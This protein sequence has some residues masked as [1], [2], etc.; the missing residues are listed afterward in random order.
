MIEISCY[1]CGFE[2][3]N[4]R[5]KVRRVSTSNYLKFEL[6]GMTGV[7]KKYANG[8]YG[9]LLDCIKNPA[10]CE[11]LFWMR[12]GELMLEKEIVREENKMAKLE[13]YKKVAVIQQGIGCYAKDYFYALYDENICVGDKV[14]I[15]GNASGQVWTIKD[16]IEKEYGITNNITSEVICKIDTTDYDERC[17]KRKQAE[18]IRKQMEKK[19]KEIE[20]RK[21]DDYYANL[22]EGYAAML[23]ELR[24]LGV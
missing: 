16:V 12:K 4:E 19:K 7:I 20:A 3:Y 2:H 8:K 10:S 23:K 22:D 14:L 5:A 18:E 9:I 6:I 13:G 24:E 11:G 1:S 17:E 15:T 21:N